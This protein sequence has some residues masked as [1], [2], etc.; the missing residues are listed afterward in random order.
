MNNPVPNQG[1]S[2]PVE[3]VA[4]KRRSAREWISRAFFEGA[5][6]VFSVL[7]ALA[8]N[9]WRSDV[10]QRARVRQAMAAIQSEIMENER[11]VR[12]SYDYHTRLVKA[13]T[14]AAEA[15]DD[16]PDLGIATHG[17][18]FPARVLRTAWDSAQNSG[19][20]SAVSYDT[21]LQLSALYARQEEYTDLSRALSNSLYD[22]IMRV[23]FDSILAQYRNFIRIQKDFADREQFLLQSYESAQAKLRNRRTRNYG[24]QWTVI[25]KLPI[26]KPQCSA[27]DA[28]R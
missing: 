3:H 25:D 23:G 7:L 18:F 24:M 12:F 9:E 8:L 21:V 19:L 20:L 4:A 14:A 1:D 15:G 5:L 26:H 22:Q 17:M 6:I 28:G 27:A 2:Q 11:L 13:F 16:H 10:A